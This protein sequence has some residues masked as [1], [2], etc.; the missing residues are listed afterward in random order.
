M[1]NEEAFNQ[2]LGKKFPKET[3]VPRKVLQICAG[4]ALI[5]FNNGFCGFLNF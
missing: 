5:N 2:I 1:K 4:S 3:F